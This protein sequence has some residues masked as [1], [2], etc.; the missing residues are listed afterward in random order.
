MEGM[1]SLNTREELI[2][3]TREGEGSERGREREGVGHIETLSHLRT[4]FWV[5]EE[6]GGGGGGG[7]VRQVLSSGEYGSGTSPGYHTPQV[8]EP[9]SWNVC[10]EMRTLL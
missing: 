7:G 9:S 10:A 6:E 2:G 3:G 5:Q 1:E 4:Q 8:P